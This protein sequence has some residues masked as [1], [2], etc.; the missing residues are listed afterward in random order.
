MRKMCVA[1]MLGLALFASPSVATQSDKPTT[2]IA[3]YYY[4][5]QVTASG[6]R[7][8][9]DGL[10]AAHRSLPFGTKVKV[11]HM[12][13]GKSV[14]VVINDRGP[15]IRGRSIDLSRGA[16]RQIDMINDGVARVTLEL[17]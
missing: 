12:N 4:H 3:S 7:F 13:N 5:G 15:F 2:V 11:T 8:N 9:P 6:Q 16:A 17:L 1:A 10:S 14:I